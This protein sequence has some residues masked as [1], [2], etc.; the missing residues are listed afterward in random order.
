M[1]GTDHGRQAFSATL[2][3]ALDREIALR[4]QISELMARV[5]ELTAKNKRILDKEVSDV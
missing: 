3:A 5:A 1:S 2:M 4:A